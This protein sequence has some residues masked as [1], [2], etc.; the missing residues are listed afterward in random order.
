[1]VVR[2]RKK[3]GGWWDKR[4]EVQE[5]VKTEFKTQTW[6]KKKVQGKLTQRAT[7]PSM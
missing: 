1:L 7:L 3:G 6:P 5:K 4:E 2:R